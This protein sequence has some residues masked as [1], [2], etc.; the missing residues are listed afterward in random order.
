MQ[1]IFKIP[2]L[3]IK[4]A[5]HI[6]DDIDLTNYWL[7]VFGHTRQLEEYIEKFECESEY[8][9]FY[10]P[11]VFSYWYPDSYKLMNIFRFKNALKQ[12]VLCVLEEFEITGNYEDMEA[13]CERSSLGTQTVRYYHNKIME[14][15]IGSVHDVL[16]ALCI[17]CRFCEPCSL[18]Y[19]ILSK[20][21]TI[22]QAK[23]SLLTQCVGPSITR[24]LKE[25]LYLICL[26]MELIYCICRDDELLFEDT[27]L[28]LAFRE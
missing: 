8:S 1:S 23:E 21:I 22:R 27:E 15:N 28:P 12:H 20:W 19:N 7:A 25:R 5:S 24:A 13:M 9:R 4:I 26:K 11:C 18:Y 3:S 16:A 6:N 14:N 10:H 2:E 17:K